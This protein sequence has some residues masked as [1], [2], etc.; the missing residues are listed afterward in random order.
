MKMWKITHFKTLNLQSVS[1]GEFQA[2]FFMK[3]MRYFPHP[4]KIVLNVL[5]CRGLHTLGK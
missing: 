1:V 3:T 5:I 4:D 2:V